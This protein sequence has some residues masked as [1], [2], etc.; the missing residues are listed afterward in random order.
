MMLEDNDIT[1]MVPSIGAR[2]KLILKRNGI[3]KVGTIS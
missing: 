3:S 2:R 1:E